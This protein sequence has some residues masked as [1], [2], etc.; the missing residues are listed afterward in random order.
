[1]SDS[2]SFQFRKGT[3]S[4]RDHRSR[5]LPALV[6]FSVGFVL[7]ELLETISD[8]YLICKYCTHFNSSNCIYR[9]IKTCINDRWS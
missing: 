2:W 1:M 3:G 4:G 5:G 9:Q 8:D 7:Q 6:S